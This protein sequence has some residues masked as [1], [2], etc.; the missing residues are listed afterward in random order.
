MSGVG[1]RLILIKKTEKDSGSR[2]SIY[3][4][5]AVYFLLAIVYVFVVIST[6]VALPS[7][8]SFL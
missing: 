8:P 5:L 2:V 7:S 6:V 1:A 3:R 4:Q